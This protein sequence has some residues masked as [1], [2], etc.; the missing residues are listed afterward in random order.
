MRRRA[1]VAGIGSFFAQPWAASAVSPVRR[2]RVGFL[3]TA[4]RERKSILPPSSKCF[5]RHGYTRGRTHLRYS[6]GEWPQ[7]CGTGERIGELASRRHRDAGNARGASRVLRHRDRTLVMAAAGDP[8]AIAHSRNRPAQNMTGFGARRAVRS[9]SAS[10][11][12]QEFHSHVSQ[13]RNR[14]R[15]FLSLHCRRA[16]ADP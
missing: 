2:Y 6:F 11:A 12:V 5:S 13:P 4:P 3:D 14:H 15:S 10:T 9:A 7:A 1:F 16:L 8:L